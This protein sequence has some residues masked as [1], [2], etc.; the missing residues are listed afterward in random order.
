MSKKKRN[1]VSEL[2]INSDENPISNN[3][4][5][6]AGNS[7]ASRAMSQ[8]WW[9]RLGKFERLAVIGISLLMVSAVLGATGLGKRIADT[10]TGDS[11]GQTIDNNS[12]PLTLN[13]VTT[14]TPQLSKEYIYAGSR[15]LAVEDANANAAPP[16]DLAIWRPSDGNWWV[17]AGTGTQQITQQWGMSGDEPVPG[18][19][20]GDGKTDFAVFRP[21]NNNWYVVYSST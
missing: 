1:R 20:D 17:M 16:A 5:S 21:S 11:A 4:D 15:L 13:P 10:F 2:N 3:S 18:D 19:Y 7:S 12:Q 6:S 9:K 14:G 8:N